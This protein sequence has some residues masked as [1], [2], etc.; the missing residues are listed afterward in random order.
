MIAQNL[1]SLKFRIQSNTRRHQYEDL[2]NNTYRST[3][4]NKLNADIFTDLGDIEKYSRRF[5]VSNTETQATTA[6]GRMSGNTQHSVGSLSRCRRYMTLIC[7]KERTR[8][9][10]LQY[11]I[12]I[13]VSISL[14]NIS[15][16]KRIQVNLKITSQIPIQILNQ[17]SP[18]DILKST[19][20]HHTSRHTSCSCPKSASLHL[21]GA[22]Y[23]LI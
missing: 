19:A 13:V 12:F 1:L 4:R 14:S 8:N 15:T 18:F 7:E 20:L 6:D 23:Q 5:H 22:T 21:R 10:W 3:P 9:R 17:K 2:Q 16:Q 11:K